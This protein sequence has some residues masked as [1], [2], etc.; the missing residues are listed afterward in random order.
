MLRYKTPII[1]I[2]QV[3]F[4]RIEVLSWH[5]KILIALDAEK[6]SPVFIYW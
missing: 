4:Q 2:L 3:D 5:N 1:G 6:I